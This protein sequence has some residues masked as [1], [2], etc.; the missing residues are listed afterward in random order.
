MAWIPPEIQIDDNFRYLSFTYL[1]DTKTS[2]DMG[3]IMSGNTP[4]S[5]KTPRRQTMDIDYMNGTVDISWQTG[6]LHFDDR[7]ITYNFAR[8]IQRG[9]DDTL[10]EMNAKCEAAIKEVT[11]W[12][13]LSDD[14]RMYD[15]GA[16]TYS[17]VRMQSLNTQKAF[18]KEFWILNMQIAFK[19]HPDLENGWSYPQYVLPKTIINPEYDYLAR[20]FTFD[21]RPAFDAYKLFVSGSTQLVDPPIKY[22]E[23]TLPFVDG[24]ENRGRFYGDTQISYTCNF[25]MDNNDNKNRMNWKCQAAVEHI[26]NWLYGVNSTDEYEGIQMKGTAKLE[27][28]ALGTFHLA[29]CTGLSVSKSMSPQYWIL[30]YNITFTTYPKITT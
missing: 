9:P 26:M 29:R 20:T 30:T 5:L 16:G 3:L 1:G 17:K 10:D 19:T 22:R 8:Y 6:Q 23:L 15:S 13:V 18:S 4:L 7:S 24:T 12:A 11:D 14:G 2:L 28:T 27:D 21:N 25:F